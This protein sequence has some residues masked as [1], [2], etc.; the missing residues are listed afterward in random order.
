MTNTTTAA[1][2]QDAR[3]SM[4]RVWLAI[5][6]VWIGFWLAIAAIV[7]AAFGNAYDLIGTFTSFSVIVLAPPLALLLFGVAGCLI[8]ECRTQ[9]RRPRSNS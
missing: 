1:M 4:L 2:H 8:F 9:D 6:S 7:V 5:S 3:Q